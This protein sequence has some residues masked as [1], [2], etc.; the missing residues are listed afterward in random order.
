MARSLNTTRAAAQRQANE[1]DTVVRIIHNGAAYRVSQY[2][3]AFPQFATVEL[4]APSSLSEY[5]AAEAL[6][7]FSKVVER[8]Q[9]SDAAERAKWSEA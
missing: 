8:A 4:V 5:E 3:H 1:N 6:R 9:A 7:V 2:P